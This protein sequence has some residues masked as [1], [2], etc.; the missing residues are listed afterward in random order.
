M[1]STDVNINGS[2]EIHSVT[3]ASKFKNR[4][5]GLEVDATL[6]Y[7]LAVKSWDWKKEHQSVGVPAWDYGLV[8]DETYLVE[9]S[10]VA[11]DGE[12]QP[13]GILSLGYSLMLGMFSYP[14][15]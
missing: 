1:A 15:A 3:S 7:R 9:P 10:L 11:L 8:A 14:L 13:F 4:I 12:G 6:I 2:N 5:R